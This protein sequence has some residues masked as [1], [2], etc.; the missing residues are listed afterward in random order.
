M[1]TGKVKLVASD[2]ASGRAHTARPASVAR[3]YFQRALGLR[4]V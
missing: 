1:T 3:S 4:Q 2:P